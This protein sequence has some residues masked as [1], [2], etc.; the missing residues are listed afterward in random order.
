[1][2]PNFRP[3]VPRGESIRKAVRWISDQRRRDLDIIEEACRRFDLSPVE[4]EFLLLHFGRHPEND[5][6][7]ESG[8]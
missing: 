3:L 1:M 2:S 4:E 5:A 7:D 8:D 6:P